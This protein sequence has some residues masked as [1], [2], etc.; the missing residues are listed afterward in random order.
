[1]ATPPHHTRL[2]G[3]ALAGF[4]LLAVI[5]TWP[6]AAAP[7]HWSRVDNGDGALNIW[8]VAWVGHHL[9]RAPWRVADA[10]I[11]YPEKLTLAYSEMMWVQ[12]AIAAPV[13]ALGGSAVLAYNVSALA[14]FAFSGWAFCLLVQRWTLSWSAGMV[15]GSLAAFNAHTLVRLTHLQALH[16]EFIALMLFAL[17]RLSRHQRFRDAGWL[18]VGFA[19]QAMTSVYLM[20]F[21]TWLMVFAGASRL[22]EWVRAG[23]GVIAI[24]LAAA[25]ALASVLLLPYLLPYQ[26][27]HATA[28][29]V[30]AADEQSAAHWANFLATG[31]RLHYEWWSRP[32]TVEATSFTFPGII[33]V[34]LV[35]V[36]WCFRA[37]RQDPRFRM[38]ALG[39]LGCLVMSTAPH[40]PFYGAIHD[41]LILFQAVRVVAHLGQ[42]T[43]LMV[44]VLAGFGV[45]GLQRR[46]GHTR[47]WPAV[48][49]AL[50]VLVNGEALRAPMGFTW[51]P[52]ISTV[53]DELAKE[54]NAVVAEIPFPIPQQWFLNGRYMVNSTRHWRP[55]LNGYSG[56]RP[57]S[58][59]ESHDALNGFPSEASLIGLHSRGATH[60]V[61]HRQSLGPGRFDA[62]A[63]VRSLQLLA[64]DD[65]IWLYR[66][67]A[68]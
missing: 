11:F 41:R 50:V 9:P 42:L 1:V 16:T 64:N 46:L 28:R 27:L 62:I 57:Q 21:S 13:M 48:A 25:A 32:F 55:L 33:A 3:L 51:F 36:A 67:V 45:A 58:Y 22:G 68:P 20:V 54:P 4:V 19:L 35:I 66:L 26:R 53:Y 29:L 15:A 49:V 59:G 30:R 43:L 8:A 24:R 60:V 44:A 5:H 40:W 17:D 7:G 61:V 38:C 37:H 52:G 23:L 18:A 47:A 63:G 34:A 39:G 10:N 56:F 6:L 65:E 2:V 12:G 31:S 14:G